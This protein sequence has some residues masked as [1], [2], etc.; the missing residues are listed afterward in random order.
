M[1]NARERQIEETNVH[2]ALQ[3]CTRAAKVLGLNSHIKTTDKATESGEDT[4]DIDL[5]TS[6]VIKHK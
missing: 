3:A 4:D 2:A 1:Q 6:P 5:I